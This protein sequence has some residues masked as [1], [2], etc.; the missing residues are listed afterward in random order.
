LAQGQNGPSDDATDEIGSIV[1]DL[2]NVFST[3]RGFATLVGEELRPSDPA[4]DDIG[5]IQKAVDRG[6]TVLH[7]LS[8]LLASGSS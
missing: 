2:R 7:R 4:R 3:I 1:H 8:A 5:Q 6:V